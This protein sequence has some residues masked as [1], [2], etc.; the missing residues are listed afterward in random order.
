MS[1]SQVI[2]LF[3]TPVV[4][5]SG[6]IDSDLVEKL[7]REIGGAEQSERN[8]FS[9]QLSHSPIS[10]MDNPLFARIGEA[11]LPSIAQFG[12]VLFG[13]ALNWQIKEIWSNVLETGGRQAIHTHANS[14]ISGVVYLTA[15]HP[16]ANLVFHKSLGGTNYI[17]SNHHK[18]ASVNAYNG[19]KWAM[20]ETLPGD[21]VMFPSYLLHEVP[22]NQ[23]PRRMSIAFNALPDRLENFGYAVRFS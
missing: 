8:A 12:E 21:L 4:R 9:E 11:V 20:P 1:Q 18:N 2:G 22:V 14:F 15:S 3:P 23:G 7:A 6:L 5:V 10:G 16:S 13:E 19:S 17:F